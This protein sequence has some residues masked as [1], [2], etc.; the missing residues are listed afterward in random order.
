MRL[1]IFHLV[2]VTLYSPLVLADVMIVRRNVPPGERS[3][4]IILVTTAN[5][6][7]VPGAKIKLT[8]LN[9]QSSTTSLTQED[10]RFISRAIVGGKYKITASASDFVSESKILTVARGLGYSVYFSLRSENKGG[11]YVAIPQGERKPKRNY[12]ASSHQAASGLNVQQTH[13]E[14]ALSPENSSQVDVLEMTFEDETRLQEWLNAQAK[15]KRR[16]LGIIALKDNTSLF[17]FASTITNIDTIYSDLS[18]S[19]IAYLVLPV[20]GPLNKDEL[21][22]RIRLHPGKIFIGSHRLSDDLYLLV[23]RYYQHSDI[24]SR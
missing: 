21:L 5:G 23:F 16:L 19:N 18:S 10:G 14:L 6:T 13:R 15:Q 2:F 12:P 8:R 1:F 7:A 20:K 17:L 11:S 9:E 24:R 4:L 22:S 3:Y